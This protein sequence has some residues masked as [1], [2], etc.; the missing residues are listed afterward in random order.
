[1]FVNNFV[2]GF[3]AIQGQ[4]TLLEQ[5][6]TGLANAFLSLADVYP[7][8]QTIGDGIFSIVDIVGSAIESIKAMG[9][10][11][12]DLSIPDWLTPGSPTPLEIGL[13]G[14][15]TSAVY[16]TSKVSDMNAEFS[17]MSNS[18]GAIADITEKL[19]LVADRSYDALESL[20]AARSEST[21]NTVNPPVDF[22]VNT[23]PDSKQNVDALILAF[24]ALDVVMLTS[25][26][27]FRS[28]FMIGNTALTGLGALMIIL[29]SQTEPAAMAIQHLHDV[30]IAAYAGIV[31][32]MKRVTAEALIMNAAL[33]ATEVPDVVTPG[34]PTPFEI[35][36]RGIAKAME[37]LSGKSL[38]DM[39]NGLSA[40]DTGF[41]AEGNKK[42]ETV[43]RD[44]IINIYNPVPE[45]GSDSLRKTMLMGS[46]LGYEE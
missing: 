30:S 28:I 13:Y 44:T 6:L 9:A 18:T 27:R 36:L 39:Q 21:T 8:F 24:A 7:V 25:E 32:G 37:S 10:A 22:G 16:A 5:F 12:M 40:I 35:G 1:M 33:A 41:I 43:E 2:G 11:L 34:S 31:E 14:I 45:K 23:A 17:G 3:V 38:P 20:R 15:G 4:G 46:Y 19:G 29:I 26:N 42:G